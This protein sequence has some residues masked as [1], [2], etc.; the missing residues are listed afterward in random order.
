MKIIDA[1]KSHV[2]TALITENGTM[3]YPELAD[4]VDE[5]S[6]SVVNGKVAIL[7]ISNTEQGIIDY[8]ACMSAG[9]ATILVPPSVTEEQIERLSEQF[10]V[11]LLI[12]AG[13]I[14]NLNPPGGNV[15]TD[16]RLLMSTSGST[17][18][19]KM[20]K[21]SGQ[22]LDAN[23]ASIAEYLNIEK[24]S[25]SITS[26]PLNYSFGLSILNSY[27]LAGASLVVTDAAITEKRFWRA[28]KEFEVSS[29]SGVPFHFETLKRLRFMSMSLPALRVMTQAG[30]K[31]PE[32]L[33]KE[34]AQFAA[35]TGRKFVVMYGQTEAAPRISYLPFYLLSQK[36][37]SIG[38]AIPGGEIFLIDDKGNRIES[39]GQE[40]ELVYRGPNVMMGYANNRKEL[41][42]GQQSDILKT[43]DLAFFDSEGD[44]FISGRKSR[45]IKIHSKRISLS[46]V[47][48]YFQ[49]EN[50]VAAVVG[51]DD[52]LA[53]VLVQDA[54]VKPC[55][56][57][58]V[59]QLSNDFGIH[60]SSINIFLVEQLP[61]NENGK[62]DYPELQKVMMYD[63]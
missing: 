47:E 21:L 42:S 61:H 3:T 27:L 37:N 28:M 54:D 10:V 43:G 44:F 23:A 31:M 19:P 34:Y 11:E 48:R 33:L 45:F 59:T 32:P 26:L 58:L 62:I 39:I 24:S 22:N 55:S 12:Q 7:K 25:R 4:R 16:L 15:H 17:G 6:R 38:R 63:K 57:S 40:G 20:V 1:L 30:G 9:V 52:H 49:K 14:Q 13:E 18:S 60:P 46:E 8:L 35:E 29:F 5:Q 53:V 41:A 36:T 50:M 2:G 51:K 56:K